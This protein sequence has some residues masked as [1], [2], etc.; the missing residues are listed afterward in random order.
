VNAHKTTDC[1]EAESCFICLAVA[2]KEGVC[3]EVASD[4]VLAAVL[5]CNLQFTCKV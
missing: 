4:S 2:R 1:R 3:N 5:Q